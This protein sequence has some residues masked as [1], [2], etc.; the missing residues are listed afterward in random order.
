MC[1]DHTQA[2]LGD[3]VGLVPDHCNK[4]NIAIKQVA[5]KKKKKLERVSL[6]DKDYFYLRIFFL[7][8]IYLFGCAGS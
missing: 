5:Q 1:K 4:M 3:I 2:Y 8:F 7:T 6:K